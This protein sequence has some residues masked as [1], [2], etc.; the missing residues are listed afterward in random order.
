[1]ALQPVDIAKARAEVCRTYKQY[2]L[3]CPHSPWRMRMNYMAAMYACAHLSATISVSAFV[4]APV[5]GY[6]LL[7]LSMCMRAL[8][9]A[10]MSAMRASRHVCRCMCAR[11]H[12]CIVVSVHCRMCGRVLVCMRVFVKLYVCLRCSTYAHACMC[13]CVCTMR[14]QACMCTLFIGWSNNQFD[15]THFTISLEKQ[16]HNCM[17]QTHNN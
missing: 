15:K 11:A 16:T 9:R 14:A 8:W 10:C 5:S 12:R 1:M 6:A 7:G 4:Y 2:F 3:Q 13:V 17:F